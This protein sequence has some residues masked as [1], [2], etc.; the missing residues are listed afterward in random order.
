MVPQGSPISVP[1]ERGSLG[2]LSN[3]CRANRPHLD[4]CPETPCSSP[5]ATG[6]S[7]LHSRFNRRVSPRLELIQRTPLSSRVATGISKRPL[8]GLKVVKPSVQF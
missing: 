8:S 2:L 3:H 4:L 7:G 6:I 5:V 1:V